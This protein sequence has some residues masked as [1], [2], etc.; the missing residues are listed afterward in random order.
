MNTDFPE[1][2]FLPIDTK[3]VEHGKSLCSNKKILFCGICRDVGKTLLK[4]I[5]R[6][7]RTASVFKEYKVF[8]Y[9][10][11]SQDLTLDIL[12]KSSDENIHFISEKR[13]DENYRKQID[14]GKDENHLN[15]CKILS[16]C[17]NKY[18]DFAKERCK[19]YDYICVLDLDIHGWS[20]SGFYNS[21]GILE[22]YPKAASVS[23]YG[24]LSDVNNTKYIEQSNSFLMYDSFAF[25]PHLFNGEMNKK[26]QLMFNFIRPNTNLPILVNSNFGGLCIYRMKNIL[27]KSYTARERNNFVDCDHVCLNEQL[28]NDG[29]TH[30]MNPNMIVSYSKH[31]YSNA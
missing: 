22:D 10:N 16:D 24:I 17:R 20:Y 23:S 26:T 25:R 19:N 29:L 18:L 12:K 21:I 6:I 27:N 3:I 2:I 7:K 13:K 14:S 31:R 5:L 11:D 15:R 8:L 4:N 28:T 1:N 9:E 30:F